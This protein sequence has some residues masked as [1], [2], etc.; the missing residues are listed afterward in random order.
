MQEQN[1]F[2]EAM[3]LIQ[4]HTARIR[5]L[6]FPTD[7]PLTLDHILALFTIPSLASNILW[8]GQKNDDYF[9][10]GQISDHSPR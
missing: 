2:T 9:R 8:Q 5:A 4:G 3:Q 7:P 1:R 6:G 10:D